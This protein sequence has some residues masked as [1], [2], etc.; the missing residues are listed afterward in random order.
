MIENFIRNANCLIEFSGE[1]IDAIRPYKCYI[2]DIILNYAAVIIGL[3]V[4]LFA[5]SFGI[6]ILG[7]TIVKII[8]FIQKIIFGKNHEK[9]YMY[10]ERHLMILKITVDLKYIFN[11]LLDIFPLAIIVYYSLEEIVNEKNSW[12]VRRWI[13]LEGLIYGMRKLFSLFI[14]LNL[15]NILA[16]LLVIIIGN[17]D[18]I[19]ENVNF[20]YEYRYFLETSSLIFTVV[21]SIIAMIY[22]V[23]GARFKSKIYSDIK[24]EKTKTLLQTEEKLLSLFQNLYVNLSKNIDSMINSKFMILSKL[25]NDIGDG[26]YMLEGAGVVPVD[27]IGNLA[28][29]SKGF[30]VD[31]TF[32]NFEDISG[33]IY[34][35][36]SILNENWVRERKIIDFIFSDEKSLLDEWGIILRLNGER[37]MDML[38]KIDIESWYNN[39]SNNIKKNAVC[40]PSEEKMK[41]VIEFAS[42]VLDSALEDAMTMEMLIAYAIKRRSK[43]DWVNNR[44][45]K[46]SIQIGG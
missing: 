17:R 33:T 28:T 3:E 22:F 1:L 32:E 8:T 2:Y 16:I 6:W 40:L 15:K 39:Y 21:V 4:C 29:F 9:A 41:N 12:K 36:N 20:N 13:S 23:T 7:D 5:I 34:E 18:W 25:T 35:I 45:S 44:I 26:K 43:K 24:H 31:Y 11:S 42:I 37:H 30:Y 38:G 46:Y 19:Y 27:N 10:R 14:G